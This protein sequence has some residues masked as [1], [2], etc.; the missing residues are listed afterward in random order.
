MG[1]RGPGSMASRLGEQYGP[2]PPSPSEVRRAKAIERLNNLARGLG[3]KIKAA[4]RGRVA[5][6]A[7][8]ARIEEL[9]GLARVRPRST[10]A[11]V[12]NK[13]GLNNTGTPNVSPWRIR[14][15]LPCLQWGEVEFYLLFGEP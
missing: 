2:A 13:V 10:F 15:S 7:P 12:G 5:I 9:I 1:L 14:L 6:V 8:V 3:L 4:S 11:R